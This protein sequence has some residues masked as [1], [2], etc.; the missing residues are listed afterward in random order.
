MER[1]R[2][3]MTPPR[4]FGY[5]YKPRPPSRSRQARAIAR[6]TAGRARRAALRPL[7]RV[8]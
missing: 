1:V 5:G 2:A 6:R 4:I 7:T 8:G 3:F